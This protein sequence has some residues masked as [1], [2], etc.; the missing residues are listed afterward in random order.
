MN[1]HPYYTDNEKDNSKFTDI[2]HVVL[3]FVIGN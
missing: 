1:T 3:L 2:K